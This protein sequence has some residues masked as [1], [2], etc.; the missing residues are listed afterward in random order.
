MSASRSSTEE[1]A[2]EEEGRR[3]GGWGRGGV[4][5]EL[6]GE[7]GGERGAHPLVNE[8]DDNGLGSEHLLMLLVQLP[9]VGERFLHLE[10]LFVLLP[11]CVEPF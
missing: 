5:G 2:P 4:G 8:H 1:L 6:L 3:D 10:D 11:Q 7:C 9:P